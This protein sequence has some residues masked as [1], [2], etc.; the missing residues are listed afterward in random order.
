MIQHILGGGPFGGVDS[1]TALDKVLSGLG[2]ILPILNG[3]KLVV[4]SDDSFRLLGLRVLV[5]RCV[6]AEEEIGD[7]AHG[8]DVDRFVMASCVVLR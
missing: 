7:D 4:A 3:L 1:E 8:P 2:D 5:E 6:T